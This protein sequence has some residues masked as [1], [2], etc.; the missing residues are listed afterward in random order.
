MTY[1]QIVGVECDIVGVE[2][3]ISSASLMFMGSLQLSKT[4][5]AQMKHTENAE[6][7]A[8]VC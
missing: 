7:E 5:C 6:Q 1:N 8:R 4:P 3:D 2:C